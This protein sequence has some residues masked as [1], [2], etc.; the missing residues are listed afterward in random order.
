MSSNINHLF[1]TFLQESL[2]YF[3]DPFPDQGYVI[4]FEKNVKLVA[5]VNNFFINN[6]FKNAKKIMPPEEVLSVESMNGEFFPHLAPVASVASNLFYFY[7]C[8]SRSVF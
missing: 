6:F 7:L 2:F 5:E 8:G 1:F 4:N 3:L